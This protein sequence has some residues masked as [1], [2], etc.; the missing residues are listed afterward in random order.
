MSDSVEDLLQRAKEH[1]RHGRNEQALAD[2]N[3]VLEKQP[4][5]VDALGQ[6]GEV[7]RRLGRYKEAIDL[8][9]QAI[10]QDPN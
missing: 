1:M 10:A 4:K 9:D 7:L 2:L 8:L 5:L 3:V 6:K